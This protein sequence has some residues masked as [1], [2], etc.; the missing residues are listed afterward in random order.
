[1]VKSRMLTYYDKYGTLRLN[2]DPLN[3]FI[4]T[5]L[6]DRFNENI[7][8]NTNAGNLFSYNSSNIFRRV[9]FNK[10]YNKII[11]ST[12]SGNVFTMNKIIN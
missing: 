12:M 10:G 11:D 5:P 4:Y 9:I 6:V 7:Q 1:M 8:I 2:V 3:E